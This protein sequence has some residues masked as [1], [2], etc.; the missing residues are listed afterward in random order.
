MVCWKCGVSRV[1]LLACV[2]SLTAPLPAMAAP[3]TPNNGDTLGAQTVVGTDTDTVTAGG[4]VSAATAITWTVNGSNPSPAPGVTIDNCGTIS[5]TT[6]ALGTSGSS[7]PRNFTLWNRAGGLITAS[8]NDA[9]QIGN[10]I[11]DGTVNVYNYGTILSTGGQ[12]LDFDTIAS[13][14]GHVNIIN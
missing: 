7:G 4:T 8:G 11:G 10:D 3:F 13:T 6:R 2:A 12:G 5:G 9:F 14:T 1:T